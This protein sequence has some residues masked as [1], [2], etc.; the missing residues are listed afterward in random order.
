[1]E[2]QSSVGEVKVDRQPDAAVDAV[3]LSIFNKTLS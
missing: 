3:T 2:K 1:M